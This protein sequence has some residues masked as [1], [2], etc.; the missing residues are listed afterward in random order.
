[1]H[2]QSH[3][4]PAFA[5]RGD[6]PIETAEEDRL[7]RSAFAKAIAAQIL[8]AP[9]LDSFVV[10]IMGPWGSGKTSL[11]NLVTEEIRLRGEAAILSFNPWLFSGTEQLVGVFFRELGAQCSELK[12]RK[13]TSVGKA[14]K[15]YAG[16]F[17]SAA[18]FAPTVGGALKKVAD[19]AG[20]AGAALAEPPSVESQRV[21]IRDQLRRMEKRIVVVIDD[22]DRLRHDEIRELVKLVRLTGDF[23]NVVYIL[24]FDRYRVEAAL[25]EQ[26]ETGRA[27]LEKIVQVAY[28]VPVALEIDITKLLVD[29]LN[30]AV[31]GL[32]HGSFD[33][34]EW[35]NVFHRLIRPLFRSPRDVR[36]YVNALPPTIRV[37]G[38][39]VALTDVLALEAVRVFLPDTFARLPGLVSALTRQ[40]SDARTD[41]H[42]KAIEKLLDDA[43]DRRS[44]VVELIRQ[45]FPFSAWRVGGYHYAPGFGRQWYRA[46]R[47]AVAEPLRFYL[48]RRLPGES[49]ATIEVDAA[50]RAIGDRALL[51]GVLDTFDAARLENLLGRL[52]MFEDEFPP[53]H[54]EAAIGALMNQLARLREGRRHAFDLGADIALDRVVLRLLRRVDAQSEREAVVSRLLPSL[55]SLSAQLGLVRLAEGYEL[56]GKEAIQS[57]KAEVLTR[58]AAAAPG[59]LAGE[60]NLVMLVAEAIHA[61]EPLANQARAVVYGNGVVIARLLASAMREQSSWSLGDVASVQEARLPWKQLVK[62][63]G[64]DFGDR[65]REVRELVS[66]AQL[67]PRCDQALDLATRYAVGW[68][69]ADRDGNPE[70]VEE[71]AEGDDADGRVEFGGGSS[72]TGGNG[73]AGSAAG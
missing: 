61:G 40:E 17:G 23:P 73:D 14:L 52:E 57:W 31:D 33:Q 32:D 62:L 21:Q 29:E 70:D 27:Y 20:E 64:D 54:A 72:R 5:L 18:Q 34:R 65:V 24:A 35:S 26:D 7:G 45:L 44:I 1:M 56:A 63:L 3:E 58:F 10:A 67:D 47:V 39:E 4:K 55:A 38:R 28:D 9:S 8:E 59:Q 11:V 46:R 50:L 51:E 30:A 68:R 66:A 15:K 36:R 43:G 6:R 60:R 53:E 71:A 16:L 25:G 69:P 19:V 12:N 48:E 2:E 13:L 37:I 41:P 22:I 49:V 42:A